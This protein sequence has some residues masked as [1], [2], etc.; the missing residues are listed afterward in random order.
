M[1]W[2]LFFDGDC[3][4]CTQSVQRAV[5]LDKHQ[6]LSFASLQG[7]L[8]HELGFEKHAAA[9]GGT[10]ILLRES[11]GVIFMR[12]DALIELAAVFGGGWRVVTLARFIPKALRDEVYRWIADN[13][14]RFKGRQESCMVPDAELRKR[15]RD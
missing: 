5:V 13:R 12:S 6:R 2:V 4:F 15:L 9:A 3:A 7:K 8:S 1:G 14:F 10:M 11:D